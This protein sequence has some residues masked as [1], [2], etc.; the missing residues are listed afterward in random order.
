MQLQEPRTRKELRRFLG[1]INY[2]REM[3]RN[4]SAL[5]SVF[6]ALTSPKVPFKWTA[7]HSKVFH[8]I[9]DAIAQAVLLAYPDFKLPF[10]VYADA[11]GKQLGGLI[12]QNDRIIACFSRTLTSHQKNYT[13]M[14]LELLSV[15]EILKEYRHLL[16][17]HR[18][19][20]HTDHKNL[21]YPT[22]TSLRVKRWKLLLEEYQPEMYYI[23]GEKNIGADSFS[24]LPRN[25]SS[26]EST[27]EDELFAVE[28]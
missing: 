12:V 3:I 7:E 11:S 16:L 1:M 6:S 4:K 22:E 27:V 5:T 14:E 18:I 10:H 20:I 23:K 25:P 28:V 24:R 8:R 26:E 9:R 2:Y 13:T 17:G 15:V 21:L 19:I